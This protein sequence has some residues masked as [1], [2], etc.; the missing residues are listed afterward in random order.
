MNT[1]E[2]L[3][4]IFAF[5]IAF[6][7]AFA[8]TPLVRRFAFKIKAVDIPKDNRRMHKRPIPR[9][10]GLAIIFGF[11]VSVLCFGEPSRRNIAMLAGA[12]IIAVMGVVD[13]IKALRAMPKFLIQIIAGLIVVIG[14]IC[15]SRYLP[16]RIS[17]PITY[18]GYCRT[19]CPLPLRSSGSY[20]LPML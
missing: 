18:T 6:V 2:T 10:G 14:G 16:I 11:M 3:F 13:D 7:F 5:I 12:V 9:L 19:G 4:L 1:Q 15:G 17:F 8:T 20:S